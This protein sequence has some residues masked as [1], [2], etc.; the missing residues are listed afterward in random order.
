[1]PQPV[2]PP[3]GWAW[4]RVL[5]ELRL[6]GTSL[7]AVARGLGRHRSWMAHV[8]TKPTPEAERAIADAIGVSPAEIWPDR[9]EVVVTPKR[10]A[11]KSED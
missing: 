10:P 8:K 7:A 2:Q 6:R 4:P 5:Y 9:Y 11:P 1:M 3:R